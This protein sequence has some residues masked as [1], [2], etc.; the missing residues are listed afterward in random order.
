MRSLIFYCI[1]ILAFSVTS[2]NSTTTIK[3]ER[4]YYNLDSLVSKQVAI[5]SDGRVRVNKKAILDG[6]NEE[7]IE[8]FN[9]KQW[10]NELKLFRDA[11]MNIPSLSGVY[12]CNCGI[13]D[14]NSNLLLNEYVPEY[15]EGKNLIRLFRIYYF[16]EL[17]QV[18]KIL[19]EEKEENELYFSSRSLLMNFEDSRW[20]MILTS[21]SIKGLQKL[22]L[23]D[24]VH[25][26]IEGKITIEDL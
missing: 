12:A 21:Y 19:I 16:K 25:Y 7:I 2:C 5:L 8:I 1:L 15:D 23:K 10:E 9:K 11:D 6:E 4:E 22:L 24:T 14:E 20:G 17:S 26:F 3:R 18:R 13:S